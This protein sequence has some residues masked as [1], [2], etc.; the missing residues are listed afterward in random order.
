MVF[1]RAGATLM[2]HTSPHVIRYLNLNESVNLIVV[3]VACLQRL[4]TDFYTFSKRSSA[5]RLV[6]ETTDIR[7]N[8]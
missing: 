7:F 1:I 2:A 4:R 5:K 8:S 6:G 3:D